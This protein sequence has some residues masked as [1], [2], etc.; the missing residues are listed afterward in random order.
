MLQRPS[1]PHMPGLKTP[2]LHHIITTP[3]PCPLSL[4]SPTAAIACICGY[5]SKDKFFSFPFFVSFLTNF[6]ETL[7]TPYSV[8]ENPSLTTTPSLH[9]RSA[10]NANLPHPRPT[11]MLT[12]HTQAP[13]WCHLNTE[14][15]TPTPPTCH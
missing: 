14:S 4:A 12:C 1:L 10:H 8:S 2:A 7:F 9:A 15:K 5:T 3:M 13:S 11:M 6:T